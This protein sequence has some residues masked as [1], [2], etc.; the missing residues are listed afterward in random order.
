MAYV[1]ILNEV[2]QHDDQDWCLCF[3]ECTYH[4]SPT[5]SEEGYRFI[6]RRPDGS[7]QP[8]RGQA[9][10]PSVICIFELLCKAYRE[11]W[12]SKK[13]LEEGISMLNDVLNKTC[14]SIG[15]RPSSE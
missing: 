1:K 10:I 4:Y 3:Q 13:S 12:L 11:G 7:L 9:R 5:C 15:T 14:S 8:A 2:R 6:W